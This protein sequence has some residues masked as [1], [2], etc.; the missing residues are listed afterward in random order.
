[1]TFNW[2]HHS[3]FWSPQWDSDVPIK[4]ILLITPSA[5]YVMWFMVPLFNPSCIKI[6]N[7]KICFLHLTIVATQLSN[8]SCP[9]NATAMNTLL[10]REES[11]GAP[12]NHFTRYTQRP[13]EEG[14]RAPMTLKM[15]YEQKPSS[16]S[17]LKYT[18]REHGFS[19]PLALLL[20]LLSRC[21][22][23]IF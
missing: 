6:F 12:V 1:M 3:L 15:S 10:G 21:F 17:R 20:R 11:I 18:A 23:C 8:P 5:V 22:L 9:G 2:V 16:Q 4:I 14:E 19:S 7:W 13:R